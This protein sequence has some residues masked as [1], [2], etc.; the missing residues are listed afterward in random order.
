MEHKVGLIENKM[1]E[2]IISVVASYFGITPEE[3]QK[4]TRRGNIVHARQICTFLIRKYTNV[5]KYALGRVYFGQDHSTVIHS[6]RLIE[7]EAPHNIRG[8]GRDLDYLSKIIEGKAPAFK[9]KVKTKFCVLVR[10][11]DMQDEYY[12]FWDNSVDANVCLQDRI[13]S[14]VNRKGPDKC[15]ES[16]MIKI[17][18]INNG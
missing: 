9:A 16:T 15:V 7:A 14:L 12:G 11:E 1:V 6:I 17:K 13:K 8:T 5:S 10:C 3:L 2:N 4:K 18:V